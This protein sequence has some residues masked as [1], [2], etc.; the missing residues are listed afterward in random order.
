MEELGSGL[1][2]KKNGEASERAGIERARKILVAY[3]QARDGLPVSAPD[4]SL[5]T[6]PWE[7]ALR[8]PSPA[9]KPDKRP[10][11]MTA[12][13]IMEARHRPP[14]RP[15]FVVGRKQAGSR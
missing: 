10:E 1:R 8:D 5:A 15:A 6:A 4:G 9:R 14:A 3:E 13:E 11:Q 2:Y 12:V 7:S